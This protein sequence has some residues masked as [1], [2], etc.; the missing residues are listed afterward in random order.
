[1]GGERTTQLQYLLQLTLRTSQNCVTA[2]F[3][4]LVKGELLRIPLPRTPLNKG[5]R[6]SRAPKEPNSRLTSH[7]LRSDRRTVVTR[8]LV[9]FAL[10]TSSVSVVNIVPRY[11]MCFR[12]A[13]TSACG[14][15]PFGPT[16]S[17]L[18]SF[19]LFLRLHALNRS[20]CVQG[21]NTERCAHH[22]IAVFIANFLANFGELRTEFSVNRKSNFAEFP[23]YV[24]G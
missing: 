8:L 9:P 23:F 24:L 17:L 1:M 16:A 19:L 21:N 4:E 15:G 22:S 11:F 6:K 5:K 13:M 3:A 20:V 12:A 18:M 14:A 7:Y 10:K 2:K